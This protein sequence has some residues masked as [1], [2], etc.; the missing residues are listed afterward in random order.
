MA[1]TAEVVIAERT[2]VVR[3]LT[4]TDVRDWM[5]TIEL[6]TRTCDPAGDALFED[7]GIEDMA[8]M[9]DA[10]AAWMSGL[11]PS[12][13][14]PLADL[15]KKVNPHFFRLRAVVQAAQVAQIRALLAGA[16]ESTLNGA[17]PP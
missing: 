11:G 2:V 3:E 14:R 16:Q 12:E 8:I 5:R 1:A 15:C 17:S 9:S 13:L 7:V 10:D 6:G 4:T